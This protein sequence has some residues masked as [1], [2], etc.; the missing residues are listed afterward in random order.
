MQSLDLSDQNTLDYSAYTTPVT[1][2]LSGM[3]SISSISPATGTAGVKG[4]RHVIGGGA[5]DTI[6]GGGG[7]NTTAIRVSHTVDHTA[8]GHDGW[9][10]RGGRIVTEVNH[11]LPPS[12]RRVDKLEVERGACEGSV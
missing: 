7:I 6:T 8:P 2:D 4:M 5:A 10:L 1:V 12:L 11:P 9:R 3:L